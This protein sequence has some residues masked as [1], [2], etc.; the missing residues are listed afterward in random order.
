MKRI[1]LEAFLRP[2]QSEERSIRQRKTL[3]ESSFWRNHEELPAFVPAHLDGLLA[4]KLE[5]F[6]RIHRGENIDEFL[7]RQ[8]LRI[9][10][11]A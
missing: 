8:S 6:A 7:R 9:E 11:G 10:Y 5:Q 3:R 4:D 1:D 2:V